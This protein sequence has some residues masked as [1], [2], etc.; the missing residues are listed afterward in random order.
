MR[1]AKTIMI[2]LMLLAIL[3]ATSASAATVDQIKLVGGTWQSAPLISGDYVAVEHSTEWYSNGALSTGGMNLYGTMTGGF[4]AWYC[5]WAGDRKMTALARTL[6]SWG[7]L[8]AFEDH[9]MQYMDNGSGA[10]VQLSPTVKY[11]AM[12]HD[13]YFGSYMWYA[14]RAAGG[15]DVVQATTGW[16]VDPILNISTAYTALATFDGTYYK[17]LGVKAGGGVDLIS[18]NGQGGLYDNFVVQAIPEL[19]GKRYL[20]LAEDRLVPGVFYG[21]LPTGG[22]EIITNSGSSWTTEIL[23]AANG[24][25]YT[26]L[27]GAE[28]SGARV[29]EALYSQ[30]VPEPGSLLALAC[31]LFGLA[32]FAVRRKKS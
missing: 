17:I 20:A 29:I 4:T 9:G 28:E 11:S 30:L 3:M 31:G 6:G 27:S 21:A 13:G 18:N 12:T 1:S 15:I 26:S 32:P 10:T 7:M 25:I 2:T 14:A 16:Y 23:G 8:A 5:G 22:I 24:K 19:A